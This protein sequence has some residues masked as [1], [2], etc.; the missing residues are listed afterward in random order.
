MY[1]NQM[2]A[3]ALAQQKMA[4]ADAQMANPYQGAALGY[5]AP[6]PA[7]D[8]TASQNLLNGVEQL[9]ALAA[10]VETR[11]CG[12]ADRAIGP[13]PQATSGGTEKQYGGGGFAH[14]LD[15]RLAAIANALKMSSE[16]LSRLERFI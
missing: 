7:V 1:D 6:S 10:S 5:A 13:V 9:L 4:Y 2:S 15:V 8:Q 14:Q 12:L 16:H 3:G 11:V